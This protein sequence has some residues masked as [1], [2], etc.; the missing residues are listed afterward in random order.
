VGPQGDDEV[1]AAERPHGT[2]TRRVLLGDSLDTSNLQAS[3][4]HG[5]LSVTLPVAELAQPH[6]I[7]IG[8][9]QSQAA[10][11]VSTSE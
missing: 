1:F 9:A 5:V 7:E 2:F 4:E 11:E 3:Y 8:S 6:K 10:I